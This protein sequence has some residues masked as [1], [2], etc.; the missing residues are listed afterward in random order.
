[1]L[2]AK[3]LSKDPTVKDIL[4]YSRVALENRAADYCVYIYC[5]S[6]DK[7]IPECGMFNEISK[8]IL[9]VVVSE[10]DSYQAKERMIRLGCSWALQRIMANNNA[11]IE[12]NEKLTKMQG[13]LRKNLDSIKTMKNNSAGITVAC[14]NMIAELEV[15]LGLKTEK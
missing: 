5:D 7:T 1:M 4:E 3:N 8:N 14:S 11:D 13:V 9:F 2:E 6:D 10:S 12:L 15:D